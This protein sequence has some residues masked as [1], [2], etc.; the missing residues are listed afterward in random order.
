[1]I[2]LR[3]TRVREAMH[4][5]Q[6]RL[7]APDGSPLDSNLF[8]LTANDQNFGSTVDNFAQAPRATRKAHA[9]GVV[10]GN[11]YI[12][13][14]L[15]EL[16]VDGVVMLDNFAA[17]HSYQRMSGGALLR[18]ETPDEYRWRTD[19]GRTP[20]TEEIMQREKRDK[21]VRINRFHYEQTPY[22]Y[23][24]DRWLQDEADVLGDRHFLSSQERYKA[25]RKA[26]RRAP[27]AYSN[28]DVF[29]VAAM[30][31]VGD[32]I[33]ET[34]GEVAFI[35]MTNVH[36]YGRGR[37]EALGAAIGALPLHDEVFVAYSSCTIQD[38]SGAFKHTSPPQAAW[39][40]GVENYLKFCAE[41]P[42]PTKV[43]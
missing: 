35:N 25:C 34:G 17:V 10:I 21:L 37:T 14:I 20:F 38:E 33:R 9:V 18:S 32:A 36:E 11:G 29:D 7:C 43:W 27:V 15:P 4:N 16:P 2:F 19:H 5:L 42:H 30:Q 12:N 39:T 3:S 6:D 41:T 28:T 8:K 24:V 40:N 31:E 26:Y 1:M 23:P 22:G 13:S